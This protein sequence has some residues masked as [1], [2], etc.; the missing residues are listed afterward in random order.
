MIAA[1]T[2]RGLEFTVSAPKGVPTLLPGVGS[3]PVRAEVVGLNL[4]TNEVSGL[5]SPPSPLSGLPRR[6]AT[7]AAESAAA[8][9]HSAHRHAT[10]TAA[11][12]VGK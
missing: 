9:R 7:A 11:L 6:R 4:L 3:P 12:T 2:S 8:E 5:V 10:T 1:A